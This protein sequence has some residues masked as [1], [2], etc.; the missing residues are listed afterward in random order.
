MSV[1]AYYKS[2]CTLYFTEVVSLCMLRH[3]CLRVSAI[4]TYNC[5]PLARA[6][7]RKD[8]DRPSKICILEEASGSALNLL[9][10]QRKMIERQEIKQYLF[11]KAKG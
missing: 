4:K 6:L 8:I 1:V 11:I 2:L 7:F 9:E 5:C 3:L 10:T